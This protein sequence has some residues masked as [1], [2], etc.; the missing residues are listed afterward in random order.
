MD[1]RAQFQLSLLGDKT[2]LLKIGKSTRILLL[3]LVVVVIVTG[4]FFSQTL[5]LFFFGL[6]FLNY[7]LLLSFRVSNNFYRRTKKSITA[8]MRVEEWPK[9]SILVPLKNEDEVIHATL[10]AIENLDYPSDRKE[11]LIV[12]EDTDLVTQRSLAQIDLPF[13]FRIIHIPELPPFTKGRALLYALSEATGTYLTVYDAESRPEP[14]QLKVAATA[15]LQ[16]NN[17]TCFQSK[18]RIS[19]AGTNWLTRNF[20]GEYYEWYERH[21]S[22]L[23]AQGLPFGLG[24]NSFF[25]SKKALEEAGA[26]DPFNVTEDADL[27]VRLSENGVK[28]QILDSVTTETCPDTPKGWINQRTRWNKGLFITQLVH[29]GRTFMSDIWRGEAW[30]SFWLPMISAALVP[31]FNLYIPIYM[32][33]GNLSLWNVYVMSVAL[34][35]L[36]SLNLVFTCAINYL[37]YRRMGI[38]VSPLRILKDWF[39]YLILHIASGVKAYAEYFISPLYWHK[40]Q[41][42]EDEKSSLIRSKKEAVT[43]Y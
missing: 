30:I 35:G 18:I 1:S 41:H 15:L 37:T 36:F 5:G 38:V 20:A 19:N 39:L 26:W 32:T 13:S 16:A 33:W 22:E 28:L 10:Q 8:S 7:I 27:S 17:E 4:V 25:V 43:T 11:V 14:S 42:L 12:V 21:L 23:S 29:L 3:S 6:G 2:A 24:G 40:T 34:W 31:F 9:F